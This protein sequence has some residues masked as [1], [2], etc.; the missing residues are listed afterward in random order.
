MS[1]VKDLWF[2]KDRKKTAKHPDNGGSKEAKR[3]LACWADPDGNEKTRAF[4]R[5]SEAA[6]Y[7]KK[8]EADAER[9]EYVDRDAGKEKFD[10]VARKW[11]RLRRIGGSTRE[12]YESVYRIHVG[13]AFGHRAV[14]VIKVS[15]IVEWL[16]EGP[17]SRLSDVMQECAYFI[18]ASV[19]DLAVADKLR[20]DNPA[21]HDI[22]PVPS[23]EPKE[24]EAWPVETVWRVRDEHPEPYR[25]IVDCEAGLGLR[26]G[27][28]FGLAE[29][30]FDWDALKVT[31]RRQVAWVGGRWVFKLPKGN[32]TRTV[33]VS[34]G[35]AA[36]LDAHKAKYP[37]VECTL[38]WMDEKGKLGDPVTVTL[39]FVWRGGRRVSGKQVLRDATYGKPIRFGTYDQGVWKPALSRAGILP[40]PEKNSRGTWIYKTGGV[41]G[42]GQHILRHFY[43]TV[44][45][46]GGVS[47]A[48]RMEFM[49][50]SKKGKVVTVA[51][52]G[53][54][55]DETFERARQAVDATL[56]RLRKIESPGTVTELRAAQ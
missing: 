52:Y 4:A 36:S 51:A 56:F 42:T 9:G 54:V 28:A 6:R 31:V 7:A 5:Q 34:R 55:T 39:L 24:R 16:Q 53:H 22:V 48:G 49:G 30:D 2:T 3:F 40:P 21:R 15:D 18:V 25:A 38:P 44:L 33:P 50:H 13:P 35:V 12:R 11:L 1:R 23:V 19:F 17:I 8:M 43:Q 27:C 47:L 41:K 10:A 45:D 29:E 20:R 32:K 26:R 37:P 46:D 14:G